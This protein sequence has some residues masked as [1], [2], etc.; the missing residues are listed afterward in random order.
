M[1]EGFVAQKPQMALLEPCVQSHKVVW[2]EVGKKVYQAVRAVI[3]NGL[4]HLARPDDVKV[5][6]STMT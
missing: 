2:L 4:S 1:Q 6:E 5:E 3:L